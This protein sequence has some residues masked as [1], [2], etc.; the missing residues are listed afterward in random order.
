MVL[1]APHHAFPKFIFFSS[2]VVSISY[3]GG[4]AR[5]RAV[6]RLPVTCF[7]FSSSS[8]PSSLKKYVGFYK[9]T[10]KYEY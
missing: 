4:K 8:L 1:E 3:H 9:K 6:K 5:A 2:L 7:F 10:K